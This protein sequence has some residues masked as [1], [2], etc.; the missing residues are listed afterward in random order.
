MNPP[1]NLRGRQLIQMEI[2]KYSGLSCLSETCSYRKECANHATAGDYRSEDGFAPDLSVLVTPEGPHFYCGTIL[3]P[4]S[5]DTDYQYPA[6]ADELGRGDWRYGLPKSYHVSENHSENRLYNHRGMAHNAEVLTKKDD[7]M[8]NDPI[9]SLI[10]FDAIEKLLSLEVIRVSEQKRLQQIQGDKCWTFGDI[11]FVQHLAEEHLSPRVRGGIKAN[12]VTR[13]NEL[14]NRGVAAVTAQIS[15]VGDTVKA[16]A[17]KAANP[18]VEAE[19][20]EAEKEDS[21]LPTKTSA[22]N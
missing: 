10:I 1:K 17:E 2:H 3:E 12:I 16:A 21:T 13:G 14:F 6:N 8:M 4:P 9:N 20:V 18:P 5:S 19:P 15:K 11:A 7:P 22:C